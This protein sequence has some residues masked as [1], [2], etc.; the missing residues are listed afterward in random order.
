VVSTDGGLGT[1]VRGGPD[2][3][4]SGPSSEGPR[5]ARRPVPRPPRSACQFDRR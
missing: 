3:R 2:F 1:D 5:R 4:G